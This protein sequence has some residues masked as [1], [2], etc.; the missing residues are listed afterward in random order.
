ML[1]AGLVEGVW[2]CCDWIWLFLFVFV[3]LLFVAMLSAIKCLVS[4]RIYRC[5]GDKGDVEDI[6]EG[7]FD[8]H[9]SAEDMVWRALRGSYT[10]DIVR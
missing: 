10:D 4:L 5:F 7:S 6:T 1:L 2:R 9:P 8:I 3:V